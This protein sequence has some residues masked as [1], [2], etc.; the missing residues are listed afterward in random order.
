MLVELVCNVLSI[1]A[2]IGVAIREGT[3]ISVKVSARLCRW[4]ARTKAWVGGR[5]PIECIR[6]AN[7]RRQIGP[8]I[9]DAIEGDASGGEDVIDVFLVEAQAGAA[10]AGVGPESAPSFLHLGSEGAHREI[11]VVRDE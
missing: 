11:H 10:G 3:E 4:M 9:G 1:R 2:R 7:V 5:N 8:E 6:I